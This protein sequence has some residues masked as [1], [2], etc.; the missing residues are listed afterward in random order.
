MY[1]YNKYIQVLTTWPVPPSAFTNPND[2]NRSAVR[3]PQCSARIQS[4]AIS[5]NTPVTP[6]LRTAT[7][8]AGGGVGRVVTVVCIAVV[9]RAD[10]AVAVPQAV[11][12]WD[13]SR[14]VYIIFKSRCAFLCARVF[15]ACAWRRG[16]PSCTV[17][18]PLCAGTRN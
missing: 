10:D 7:C 1:L 6:A 4:R 8:V 15:G 18:S 9:E 17:V 13:P 14:L 5:T 11:C 3:L 16:L 2:E 12:L